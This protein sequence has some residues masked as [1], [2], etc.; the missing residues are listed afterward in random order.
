[1]L[2]GKELGMCSIYEFI[3]TFR[4]SVESPFPDITS[5]EAVNALNMMK[6]LKEEIASG[7]YIIN[8]MITHTFSFKY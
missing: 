8:P 3:H 4:K 2:T 7:I 5:E 1:M 6:R